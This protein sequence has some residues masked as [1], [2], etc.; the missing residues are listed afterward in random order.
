MNKLF[1]YI[2]LVLGVAGICLDAIWIVQLTIN[3]GRLA[4]PD[5]PQTINELMLIFIIAFG[6]IS[7][8]LAY[9]GIKK[10]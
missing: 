4:I 2:M 5:S 6:A 9:L 3:F 10:V 8:I 7:L 1:G